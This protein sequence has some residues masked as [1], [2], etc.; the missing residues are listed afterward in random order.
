MFGVRVKPLRR[1]LQFALVLDGAEAGL[2]ALIFQHF[3]KAWRI[4]DHV[5]AQRLQAARWRHVLAGAEQQVALAVD[6][7][8]IR[9]TARLAGAAHVVRRDGGRKTRF[10]RA[11]IMGKAHVAVDAEHGL[12]RIAVFHGRVELAQLA[13]QAGN[14]R[15]ELLAQDVVAGLVHHK[16]GTVVVVAQFT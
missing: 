12:L 16:P 2:Q 13:D 7:Q 4:V 14:Q 8:I 15:Q 11:F 6:L 1:A 10:I 3:G 5:L 9:G